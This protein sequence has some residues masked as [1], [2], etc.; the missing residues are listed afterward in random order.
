MTKKII[1]LIFYVIAA[2]Y[3]F[4]MLDL[5]FRFNYIFEVGRVITRS[6]NFIP[7]KTI[8]FYADI[9]GNFLQSLSDINIL[10]N[11]VAFIPY[12]MYL[13]V[14]R[15]RKT[16]AKGLLIVVLTSI[17]IEMIQLAFGLGACDIDDVLLNSIG[18]VIGLLVYAL[19]R[20]LFRGEEQAKTAI[21]VGSV[22]VGVPVIY[23]Y[24]TTVFNH[25]RL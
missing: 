6:Y 22:L 3:L 5:F 19:I 20:K 24:F 16:F 18:G 15:K 2:F 11:V 14:I 9:H 17:A 21:M 4:M 13:Q 12:G 25:L 23:L 7:F 1:N 8:L 10:G